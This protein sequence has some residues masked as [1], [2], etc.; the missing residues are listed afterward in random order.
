LAVQRAPL[1]VQNWPPPPPAMPQQ[2]WASAPQ[3][4]PAG[5]LQVPA[6]QVPLT[7]VPLQVWPAAVH[8]R[9]VP[10]PASLAC[11]I[12]QP[13][14]LQELLG[15][16]AC[17]GAPQA[18]VPLLPPAWVTPVLPPMP[19]LAG[20]LLPHPFRI[21]IRAAAKAM[22]QTWLAVPRRFCPRWENAFTIL[23]VMVDVA[24]CEVVG[25]KS[26]TRNLF[27]TQSS[28]FKQALPD[29]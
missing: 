24:L 4:A 1:A 16:Q 11:G 21:I 23:V 27:I 18:A 20:L 29:S 13:P 2:A 19:P 28:F 10:P 17:P 26:R 12:Q 25:G 5:S 6:E 9:T 3:G 22:P 8:I 14:P 7:P 15:Q